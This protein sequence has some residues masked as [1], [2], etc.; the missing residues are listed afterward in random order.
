MPSI[1]HLVLGSLLAAQLVAGH[2]FAQ[3]VPDSVRDAINA[4]L[5]VHLDG[6]PQAEIK[7][8]PMA[9][10]YKIDLGGG[11]FL[12]TNGDGSYMIAGEL[13][14]FS[15]D[16]LVNLAEQDRK[17]ERQ[18]R[19]KALD[20]KKAIVFAPKGETKAV[21]NVFTDVDCGYCQLFHQQVPE[22]NAAGVEIRYLAFPRGGI[23]SPTYPKMVTAWCSANPKETLTALKNREKVDIKTCEENPVLEEFE[24]GNAFG[25]R[26]TPSLVMMDGTLIPGYK[27]AEELLVDLGIKQQ[28]N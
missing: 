21:L 25:V 2:A 15:G 1:K 17:G 10:I 4:R 22:L 12:Y 3:G 5:K 8:T 6:E 23:T 13:Y 19:L 11:Q 18:S 26:G 16:K 7:M 28:A 24:M 27:P 14:D 9:G 20:V